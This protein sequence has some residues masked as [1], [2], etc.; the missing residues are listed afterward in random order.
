MEPIFPVGCGGAGFHKP[1]SY[2][3]PAFMRIW[4]SGFGFPRAQGMMLPAP[5]PPRSQQSLSRGACRG[6][7]LKC[8]TKIS[9][10]ESSR[11]M[12]GWVCCCHSSVLGSLDSS[13]PREGQG[14]GRQCPCWTCGG[15]KGCVYSGQ[16]PRK[17]EYVRKRLYLL[18]PAFWASTPSVVL[19]L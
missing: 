10:D 6:G 5:A 15:G 11:F 16:Q 8:S 12:P 1:R 9:Q 18:W 4:T 13:I 14:K 19:T 7:S 17:S 3:S 2:G